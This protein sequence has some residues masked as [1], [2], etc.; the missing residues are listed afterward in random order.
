M[1]AA[2]LQVAVRAGEI[3]VRQGDPHADRFYIVESGELKVEISGV[4]GEVSDRLVRGSYFGERA[5]IKASDN[6]R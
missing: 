2:L 4:T 3:V 1:A 5:L 6:L